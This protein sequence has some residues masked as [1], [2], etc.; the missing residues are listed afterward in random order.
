MLL[1]NHQYVYVYIFLKVFFYVR[2][3]LF[4]FRIVGVSTC[5]QKNTVYLFPVRFRS[6]SIFSFIQ[7]LLKRCIFQRFVLRRCLILKDLTY[8]C[9]WYTIVN[10]SFTRAHLAYYFSLICIIPHSCRIY[11]V[12]KSAIILIIVFKSSKN[13]V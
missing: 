2:N 3:I 8:G 1:C 9:T 12:A 7:K 11:Y 5:I 10:T 13:V 6:L 4:Q